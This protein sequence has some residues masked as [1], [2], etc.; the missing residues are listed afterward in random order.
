M[1]RLSSV[2]IALDFSVRLSRSASSGVVSERHLLFYTLLAL[3]LAP[4]ARIRRVRLREPLFV[5]LRAPYRYK[6]AKH[7]LSLSRQ[8]LL[9]SLDLGHGLGPAR[10]SSLGSALLS[11]S[12]VRVAR[13][14]SQAEW[15]L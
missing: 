14:G 2:E 5:V 7:E 6:L 8:R 3:S 13:F 15:L 12:W 9:V 1:S 11:P 10:L 4:G